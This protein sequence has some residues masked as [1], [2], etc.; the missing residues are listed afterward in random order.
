MIDK[1]GKLIDKTPGEKTD[2]EIATGL[3]KAFCDSDIVFLYLKSKRPP[4][5]TFI[6]DILKTYDDK[7]SNNLKFK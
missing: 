2:S 7:I 5:R 3:F 6:A 4:Y 1:S